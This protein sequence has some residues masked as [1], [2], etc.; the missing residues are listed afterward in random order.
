MHNHT[1]TESVRLDKVVAA[2]PSVSSRSRA[3][4]AISTGKVLIDGEVCTEVGFMVPAGCEVQLQWNRPGTG[5]DRVAGKK[6]L[7]EAGLDIVFED[8]HLVAVCKPSGMLTDTASVEQHRTRDSVW[9]RL[10]AYLRASGDLPRTV[11]RIDRDTS[12]VVLFAR[13][14]PAEYNLRDQ[15]RKHKPT[16]SY[17]A[18]IHAKPSWDE[19][20]WLDWT[21]WNGA[22][23]KLVKIPDDGD[24]GKETRCHVTVRRR[25]IRNASEIEVRLH[26]GRRNQIR[27]QAAVRGYPLLGERLYV[28]RPW[29]MKVP[30]QMLHARTLGVVHP[31]TG[32]PITLRARI[33][34]DYARAVSLLS[35]E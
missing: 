26:T 5:K 21:R 14:D 7:L 22:A 34:S 31:I 6:G 2:F 17:L 33:P 9:K 27:L 13:T 15:F 3:K 23:R 1:T 30:R 4:D 24:G 18:L 19:N 12:G 28:D 10:R 8:E 25:F 35:R 29:G 16:R 32:R 11:H 20:E